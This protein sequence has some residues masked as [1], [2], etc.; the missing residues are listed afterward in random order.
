MRIFLLF[1]LLGTSVLSAQDKASGLQVRFVAQHLPKGLPEVVAVAGEE[2]SEPF[3]I[4]K[5]N[6]SER[7]KVPGREFILQTAS[8][9]K[10]LSKVT[11]P[12][13]GSDFIV[14]LVP[15]TETVFR[16]IVLN[17]RNAAFRPGDFYLLNTSKET[18]V[19]KVGTTQCM[20][21][22]GEGE[23]VRPAGAKE[24]KFYDVL[25]GIRDG[26]KSARPLSSSRWP[27]SKRMRTYVFF[28]DDAAKK[29][30]DFRAVDEFVPEEKQ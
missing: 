13:A 27:L 23:V 17:S 4:P 9:V 30:V 18:I 15:G 21:K 22:P 6:L 29:N 28:F 14:L 16:A 25:L 11:L 3:K 26:E 8:P 7:F 20:L 19:G 12:E 5:N 1:L 2:S 24:E 10:Q